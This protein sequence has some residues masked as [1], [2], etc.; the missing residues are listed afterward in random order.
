MK[1]GSVNKD[2]ESGTILQKTKLLKE[3]TRNLLPMWMVKTRTKPQGTSLPHYEQRW[4]QKEN[5]E[6][7]PSEGQQRPIGS[8]R[9]PPIVLTSSVNLIQLQKTLKDLAR[10]SL[11]FR[12]TRNGKVRTLNFL[13]M[14]FLASR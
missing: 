5:E 2:A 6:G 7:Q 9:P 12:N 14:Y 1:K 8:G 10:G 3:E 4:K 13:K 11:E